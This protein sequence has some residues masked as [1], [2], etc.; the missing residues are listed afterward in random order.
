[1]CSLVV[2]KGALIW[3]LDTILVTGCH[4]DSAPVPASSRAT[5]KQF[6]GTSH[7]LWAVSS[8]STLRGALMVG[9]VC[10]HHPFR[11]GIGVARHKQIADFPE[12]VSL[13]TSCLLPTLLSSNPS[14][15][16]VPPGR[17]TAISANDVVAAYPAHRSPQAF[18][19]FM[20]GEEAVKETLQLLQR[21]INSP[22]VPQE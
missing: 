17:P 14:P 15:S 18:L 8:L 19:V 12:S 13:T 4:L 2:Q 5:S 6:P 20:L 1:M 11:F 7:L 10:R 16:L 9:H 21:K 3:T 22:T